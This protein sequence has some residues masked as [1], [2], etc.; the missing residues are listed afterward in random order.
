MGRPIVLSA[1]EYALL[2]EL[3]DEARAENE[4]LREA[5]HFFAD[6]GSYEEGGKVRKVP[7]PLQVRAR[8]ALRS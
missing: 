4:R 6:G 7:W 3:K 2:I 5:L 8:E 1:R